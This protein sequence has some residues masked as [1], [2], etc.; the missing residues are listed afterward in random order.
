[1]KYEHAYKYL[2]LFWHPTFIFSII[3]HT[4]A[5]HIYIYANYILGEAP[6]S[7]ELVYKRIAHSYIPQKPNINHGM[8][9]NLASLHHLV[10]RW[11]LV[12]F[13]IRYHGNQLSCLM[14]IG[15]QVL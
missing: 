6:P 5:Y 1:M 7:Y 14:A 12:C 11:S 10:Y 15:Y 3:L 2:T 9:V 13:S 8:C 4:F